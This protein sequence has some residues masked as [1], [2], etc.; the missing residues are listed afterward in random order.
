MICK[1]CGKQLSEKRKTCTYCGAV[2]PH[3][4]QTTAPKKKLWPW[5]LGAAVLVMAVVAIVL[6]FTS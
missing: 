6:L 5:V 2:Q 1:E 3:I 4:A